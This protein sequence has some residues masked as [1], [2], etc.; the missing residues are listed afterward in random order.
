MTWLRH[1][2]AVSFVTVV[3]AVLLYPLPTGEREGQDLLVTTATISSSRASL[4][5]G[6][7]VERGPQA[8]LAETSLLRQCYSDGRVTPSLE[9]VR[10]E[11]LGSR[12]SA[13]ARRW[14]SRGR[15]TIPRD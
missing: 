3:L 5:E 14:K 12:I 4:A 7:E 1:I 6:V 11:E 2:V 10:F 9:S 15:R 8:T 13:E